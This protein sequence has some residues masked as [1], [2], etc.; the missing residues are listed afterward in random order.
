MS[1]VE[2]QPTPQAKNSAIAKLTKVQKLAGLLVMLGPEGASRI[3]KNL[4]PSEVEAISAEITNI[5]LLDQDLQ[6]DLLEEFSE[7]AVQAGTALTGGL[8]FTRTALEKAVGLFKASEIIGRVSPTRTPVAAMQSVSDMESRQI[9]NLIRHE[10]PQTIALVLSYLPPDKAAETM[11]FFHV[12]TRD[13]IIERIATLAPTPIEVVEKVVEILV[14][15]RGVSQTRALNQ[16]GGLKT[17]ADLL[18][19]MDKNIGKSLL[20]AIEERNAELG[21][22]IRQKMFTFEDLVRLDTTVLQRIL[23]E[24]DLRDLSIALKTSSDKLKTA[25][26]GCISKRAAETVSEEMSFMG[27]VKLRDVESA[28]MRII[29]IVRKLEAEGEIDLGEARKG[30]G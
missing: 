29:E 8:D 1:A 10:Q 12:D 9:F 13:R 15:K 14:S 20:T 30:G 21:L 25:L 22:A 3:L 7:L 17:A 28:Q 27:P 6:R 24:V 4:D 2:T 26:L 23:R 11:S 16:T 19:A 5:S 18:N